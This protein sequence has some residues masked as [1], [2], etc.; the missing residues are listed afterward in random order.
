MIVPSADAL[1]IEA[2]VAPQ[3]IDQVAARRQGGV[4]IMA[5]N[6]RTTPDLS[7][8][9]THVAADLTREQQTDQAY[10]L[11]RVT[12]AEGEVKRLGDLKLVPGMPAEAY[13]QTRTARRSNTSSSR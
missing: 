6:Q 3:D 5:G 1:V 13:I 11:V 4:R 9:S 10:Y 7:G 2:K 12:L 8:V